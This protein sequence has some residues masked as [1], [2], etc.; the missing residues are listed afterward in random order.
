MN[1]IVVTVMKCSCP[2][3]HGLLEGT[4]IREWSLS[5]QGNNALKYFSSF[6]IFKKNWSLLLVYNA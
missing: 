3:N 4:D 6:S 5:H 1:S 2:Y